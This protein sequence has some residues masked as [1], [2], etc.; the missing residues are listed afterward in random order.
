MMIYAITPYTPG[1]DAAHVLVARCH[2]TAD[3]EMELAPPEHQPDDAPGAAQVI[4]CAECR[5]IL[6]LLLTIEAGADV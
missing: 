3:T 4:V 2:P 6:C 1:I 5:E